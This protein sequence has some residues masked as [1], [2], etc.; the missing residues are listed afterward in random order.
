MTIYRSDG[1]WHVSVD[2]VASIIH[3]LFHSYVVYLCLGLCFRKDQRFPR[4]NRWL[5]V[6]NLI[7]LVVATVLLMQARGFF[8]V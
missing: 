8:N 5:L 3:V 7:G 2:L 4:F 6:F 1:G